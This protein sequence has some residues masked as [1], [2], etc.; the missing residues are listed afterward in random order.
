[1]GQDQRETTSRI[2]TQ[3]QDERRREAQTLRPRQSKVGQDQRETTFRTETKRQDECRREA[4]TFRPRQSKVGKNQSGQEIQIVSQL[5]RFGAAIPDLTS[6]KLRWKAAWVFSSRTIAW[7]GTQPRKCL[8]G[9]APLSARGAG[10]YRSLPGGYCLPYPEKD[11]RAAAPEPWCASSIRR[12][13]WSS[14][15]ERLMTKSDRRH[16][17]AG[18][19]SNPWRYPPLHPFLFRHAEN[20]PQCWAVCRVEENAPV[21]GVKQKSGVTGQEIVN[22][23]AHHGAERQQHCRRHP[24][25]RLQLTGAKKHRLQNVNQSNKLRFDEAF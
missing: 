23:R 3:R 20:R 24:S 12:Y 13:S 14:S 18:V 1:M 6:A 7:P 16:G 19:S 25:D 2:E 4:Q 11:R 22:I 17:G 21:A 10:R 5:L 8:S 9:N 15:P